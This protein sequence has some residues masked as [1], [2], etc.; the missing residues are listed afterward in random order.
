M[1][2]IALARHGESEAS[3][4]GVVGGDTPLTPAG[5]SQAEALA[6]ALETSSIDL[7]VTSDALRARETAAIALSGR[8]APIEILPELRDACFGAFEGRPLAEYREWIET[9]PPDAIPPGDGESRAA[10]M[11]RFAVAF[12]RVLAR[13][14]RFVLVVAHGLTL[15]AVIDPKPRPVVEL[16]YGKLVRLGRAELEEAVTRLERWCE[17]PAW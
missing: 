15:S 17:A 9:H 5:R 1:D 8:D 6:R 14:S 16:P 4:L 11:R 10:T 12:R 2:E 3:A 13:P 7:C